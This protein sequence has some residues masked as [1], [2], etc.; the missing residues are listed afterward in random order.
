M[1]NF[2][3]LALYRLFV[4]LNDAEEHI[5]LIDTDTAMS[6]ITD[7]LYEHFEGATVSEGYGIYKHEDGSRVKEKTVIIELFYVSDFEVSCLV[8]HLKK[9]LNQESVSVMRISAGVEFA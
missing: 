3:E 5:Q 4:G 8:N 7:Y 6:L 2:T 1:F 9:V